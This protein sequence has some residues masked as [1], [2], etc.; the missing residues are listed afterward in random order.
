MIAADGVVGSAE[1]EARFD[2]QATVA[3]E[4]AKPAEH[5]VSCLPFPFLL[6][7]NAT[8]TDA[9][10]APRSALARQATGVSGSLVR[11]LRLRL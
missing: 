10:S 2:E 1:K 7:R 5:E 4:L 11:P 8:A 9:P 6:S 3:A